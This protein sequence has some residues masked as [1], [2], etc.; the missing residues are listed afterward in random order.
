[1]MVKGRRGEEAAKRLH[2]DGRRP[3]RHLHTHARPQRLLRNNGLPTTA[4]A[5]VKL[6]LFLVRLNSHRSQQN[7]FLQL[8]VLCGKATNRFPSAILAAAL[9]RLLVTAA[10]PLPSPASSS[11]PPLARQPPMPLRRQW[12]EWD[13][14]VG[15]EEVA[16]RSSTSSRRGA[17]CGVGCAAVAALQASSSRCS[18]WQRCHP[19]LRRATSSRGLVPTNRAGSSHRLRNGS[20][21]VAVG[22][23]FCSSRRSGA[24]L[25]LDLT[26]Q[27]R[28]LLL[29]LLLPVDSS[30]PIHSV[31]HH[32]LSNR[33]AGENNRLC[34]RP[35][36]RPCGA[37]K[38]RQRRHA[39]RC[40]SP[41]T[42]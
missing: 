23:R 38:R 29:L 1:M 21:T 33:I 28:L 8:E 42:R 36:Q 32:P 15:V 7:P 2:V 27:R 16:T 9:F 31:A 6:R 4:P 17:A 12:A 40:S 3:H 11:T 5:T 19:I 24:S 22:G 41:T 20:S 10:P 25:P 35:C 39:Q 30:L 18:R 34:R 14:T 26:P 13:R 37:S